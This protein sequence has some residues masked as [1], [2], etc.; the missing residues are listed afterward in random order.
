MHIDRSHQWCFTVLNI[1]TGMLLFDWLIHMEFYFSLF[2][3]LSSL[4]S[5]ITLCDNDNIQFFVHTCLFIHGSRECR[6]LI[7]GLMRMF[8][9]AMFFLIGMSFFYN[10][11]LKW[12]KKILFI[13]KSWEIFRYYFQ[14]VFNSFEKKKRKKKKIR[15][16]ISFRL[17]AHVYVVI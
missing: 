16:N 12:N 1:H 10:H 2:L 4:I 8:H 11:H 6:I 7:L 9:V 14:S 17:F 3:S 5:F 15:F 13:A